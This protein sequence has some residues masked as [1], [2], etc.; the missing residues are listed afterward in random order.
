MNIPQCKEV[1]QLSISG[2]MAL[3]LGLLSKCIGVLTLLKHPYPRDVQEPVQY[4]TIRVHAEWGNRPSSGSNAGRTDLSINS[5]EGYLTKLGGRVK[6]E[7]PIRTL[8]LSKC[9]G[10]KEDSSSGKANCFQLSLVTKKVL[11]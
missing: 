8:D 11:F 5:K 3:L 4:E 6:D 2:L 1:E 9:E 7:T 10:I